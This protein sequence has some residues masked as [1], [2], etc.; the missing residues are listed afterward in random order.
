MPFNYSRQSE[1]VNL[2]LDSDTT[3]TTLLLIVLDSI[4]EEV[5]FNQEDTM[6]LLIEIQETFGVAL[7]QSNEAKLLALIAAMQ[8]D[9]FYYDPSV[10]EVIC[11]TLF[12]GDPDL[13]FVTGDGLGIDEALWGIWEVNLATDNQ[14]PEYSVLVAATVRQLYQQAIRDN[15]D[16]DLLTN[17]LA[18]K[19]SRMKQE[20]VMSGF[21]EVK[22]FPELDVPEFLLEQD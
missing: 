16:L 2:L 14:A 9:S 22:D 17:S 21:E 5:V 10:F 18:A 19:H 7:P 1:R 12:S 20:F 15:E 13:D 11:K 8:N 4:P 6:F 3:A